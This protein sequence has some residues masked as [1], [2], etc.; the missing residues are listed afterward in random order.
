VGRDRDGQ[1]AGDGQA[2]DEEP[3]A[4]AG[5]VRCGGAARYSHER[6]V[7]GAK[8]LLPVVA[9]AVEDELLAARK[10]LDELGS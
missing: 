6:S 9:S 1:D 2:R 7:G 4:V 10:R 5:A 3:Q 8:P